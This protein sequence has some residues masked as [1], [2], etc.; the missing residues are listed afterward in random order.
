MI[1]TYFVDGDKGG[2]GKSFAARA[3]ADM[4]MQSARFKLPK[5]IRQLLVVD[6]DESNQDVCG[7]GG[8]PEI[9][10]VNGCNVRGMF[11]PI[12]TPQQW[13]QAGDR[14][15]DAIPQWGD[16]EGRV[17]FSLPAGAGLAIAKAAEVTA[18]MEA[19]NAVHVWVIGTD[20]GSVEQLQQ[21]IDAFPAFYQQ[22]FVIR[23]LRHGVADDFTHWN[24]SATRA[25]VKDWGWQE[26]DLPV[27]TPSV[28][29]DLAR[30]PLHIA[31]RDKASTNG[32]KLGLG[33]Q[34]SVKT[35]RGIAGDRLA[36]LE[37]FTPKMSAEVSADVSTNPN[38]AFA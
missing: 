34:V 19:L 23:N 2:V 30:T 18:V 4:L 11:A 13:V 29:S 22:G 8:F 12:S 14:V 5:P 9:E 28:A 17:V 15:F 32:K 10:T 35:F 1:K 26:I 38:G 31:E 27:L 36:A 3:I 25:A 24:K 20:A 7:D 16:D 33:S 21:R 37:R 6:A